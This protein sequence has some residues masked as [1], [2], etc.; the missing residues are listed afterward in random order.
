[1][2]EGTDEFADR[3][4]HR[5]SAPAGRRQARRVATELRQLAELDA[6][7]ERSKPKAD[8]SRGR[9]GRASRSSRRRRRGGRRW[10]SAGRRD[11]ARLQP[12]PRLAGRPRSSGALFASAPG[13]VVGPDPRSTA[14]TSAAVE[15]TV[16]RR[17]HVL[18]AVKDQ[19]TNEHAPAPPAAVLQRLRGGLRMKAKVKDLRTRGRPQVAAALRSR[20]R[21]RAR[22]VRSAWL[23]AAWRR[24][25]RRG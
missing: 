21:S 15:A 8:A 23:R 13:Q 2:F 25:A 6:R 19:L 24:A 9:C 1:M 3:P 16:A 14:G 18:R 22:L 17:H 7:V 12:D 10:R 20:A 5:H 11:V 4:G